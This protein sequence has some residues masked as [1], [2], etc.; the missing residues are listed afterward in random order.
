MKKSISGVCP[1]LVD[2]VNNY[3]LL[4]GMIQTII[5]IHMSVFYIA[6]IQTKNEAH[7]AILADFLHSYKKNWN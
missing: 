5:D 4:P 1:S 3:N 2:A 7:Y 6:L